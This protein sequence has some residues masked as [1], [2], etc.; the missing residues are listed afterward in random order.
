MKYYECLPVPS[1]KRINFAKQ[2]SQNLNDESTRIPG[3]IY[4]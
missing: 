3:E 4:P 1:A 2:V